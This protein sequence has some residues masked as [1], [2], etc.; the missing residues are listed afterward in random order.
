MRIAICVL[1]LHAFGPLCAQSA[2][3]LISEGERLTRGPQPDLPQA[4]SKFTAALDLARTQNN[5]PLEA[6]ALSRVGQTHLRLEN[7]DEGLRYLE[8]AVPLLASLGDRAAHSSAMHNLGTAMW[9][10]GDAAG[11]LTKMEAALAIRREIG[12]KVGQGYTLRGIATCYWSLGEAAEALDYQR[13]ALALRISLKDAAGEADS[14]NAIG[15]LYALLGDPARANAEFEQSKAIY[16]KLGDPRQ[17]SF[18]DNN[19]GWT[20]VGLRRFQDAIPYLTSALAAFEQA[21]FRS[22]QAYAL[23]NL[24]N[25]YAGLNQPAK[26]AEYYERSLRIKREIGDRWAEYYTLHAMGE[27]TGNEELLRQALAG[28]RAVRDRTGLILTLGSLAKLHRDQGNTAAAES[29]IREAI[30]EIESSRSKLV[31]QDLR[32]SYLASQRDY[33]EFLIDLLARQG[34]AAEALEVAEQARGRLLL[35]RLGDVVAQI[36]K[37]ADYRAEAAARRK[38]NAIADRLERFASANAKQTQE[39]KL[40]KE[41]DAALAGLRDASEAL[42]KASPRYADLVEP[43]RVT[44]AAMQRMLRP[45]EILLTYALGR[46][47]SYLWTVSAQAIAMETLAPQERIENQ[48]AKLAQAIS[49]KSADWETKARDLQRMVA[50]KGIP[51]NATRVIVAADGS[52]EALPFAV[53]PAFGPSR[54]IAYLPSV[55]ALALLRSRRPTAMPRGDSVLALADPVLSPEDPRLPAP[56][57]ATDELKLPRLRFSRQ[58]AEGIAALAPGSTRK[59]LDFDAS[60]G[61]L[62]GA[63]PRRH[64]ILH[65]ATHAT[66]DAVHPDLS[67]VVLSAFDAGG[68]RVEHSVRLYEIYGLDLPAR[69]VSLSACRSAAGAVLPGEG[70]VSLTR[71]FQ[72]AGAASVLATLW[73]VEDR[74]TAQWMEEF[75]RALLVRKTGASRAALEASAAI[76]ARPEWSHPYYWAGFVL[77]GEWR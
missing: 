36:R 55:S 67:K 17:A 16:L 52:L 65:L 51:A 45:G 23:H 25:A 35:D 2:Q 75:Y 4:L 39:A 14:R 5:R 3:D 56:P 63:E 33:Y 9:S 49:S 59:A 73:D 57:G 71:G 60:R 46:E 31:S 41:L 20:A 74:S 76:R 1:V 34:R 61:L 44:A 11:A 58:E 47:R 19:L 22:G 43:Q 69:L 40:R 8:L 24:G 50:P 64:S 66:V 13:Q 54:E 38:V 15:L 21:K 62:L 53:L 30:H 72:Y 27:S 42:R 70:L 6:R 28:R 68:K 29:E 48:A 12:D 10:L 77:H 26:A 7:N 18:G 32:A 37:G